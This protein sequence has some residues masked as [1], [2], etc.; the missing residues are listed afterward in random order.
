MG[1]L[2]LLGQVRF[3][4]LLRGVELGGGVPKKLWQT[5]KVCQSVWRKGDGGILNFELG[6]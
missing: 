6:K 2:G 1:L 5:L 4:E 3:V